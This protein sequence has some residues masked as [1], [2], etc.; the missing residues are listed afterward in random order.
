M[1][2]DGEILCAESGW[3]R[4]GTGNQ[5][6]GSDAYQPQTETGFQPEYSSV[7]SALR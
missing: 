2:V 5:P 7:L 3:R 6:E 4:P 1:V